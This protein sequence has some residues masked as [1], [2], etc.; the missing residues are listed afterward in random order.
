MTD[1]VDTYPRWAKK[2]A[3]AIRARLGNTFV[4]HG[5][6]NDLVPV[7]QAEGSSGSAAFVPLTGFLSD[8][9]FGQ[10]DVVIEYQRANG[11]VFHTPKSHKCFVE[12]VEIVDAV[13][14]TDLARSLPRDPGT[15]FSL[16]D[17][18]LKQNV[19]KEQPLGVAILLPYAET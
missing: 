2:L 18:F 7:P 10:R 8:W 14:G 15:V 4:L 1:V 19:H 9:I 5:N 17:S 16:L 3:H 12:S 11:A 13:H 6:T